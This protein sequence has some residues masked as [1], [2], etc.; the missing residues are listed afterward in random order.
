V[1]RNA[2]GDVINTQMIEGS[3]PK[4]QLSRKDPEKH[5][6][7]I[8]KDIAGAIASSKSVGNFAYY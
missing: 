4:P 8:V 3:Q 5:S 7:L 6:Q 2:E 1:V